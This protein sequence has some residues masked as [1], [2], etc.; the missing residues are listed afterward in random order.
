MWSWVSVSRGFEGLGWI[1]GAGAP[2]VRVALCCWNWLVCLDSFVE[3]DAL[4]L[5]VLGTDWFVRVGQFAESF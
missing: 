5:L 4:M 2:L 1:W 3:F